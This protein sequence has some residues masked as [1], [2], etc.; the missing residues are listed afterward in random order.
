MG[1][2]R[3]RIRDG[4]G[5]DLD[6]FGLIWTDLDGSARIGTDWGR[7][8]TDWGRIADGLGTDWGRI[9]ITKMIGIDLG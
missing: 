5:T 7:I 1:T 8:G 9:G 2:D 6:G 4:L 3:G